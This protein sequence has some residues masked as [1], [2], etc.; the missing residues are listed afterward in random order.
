MLFMGQEM[1]EDTKFLPQPTPLDWSKADTNAP[2]R[3]FYKD[4]IRLRRNVDGA[5]A[6]LAGKN[7]A[8]THLND[9]GGNKVIAYRRWGAA[10]DDVMV[11]ANFGAKRYTRYDIGVPSAGAWQARVD[12]DA[13]KYG[14]DFGTAAPTSVTVTAATRDGMPATA[15]VAL[16]PYSMV[17]LTR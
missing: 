7:V 8:V 10:G 15:G 1:L 3:A 13:T 11:V 9:S 17:V 12:S 4:M 5:S 6:G 2:V 14:A 16:A